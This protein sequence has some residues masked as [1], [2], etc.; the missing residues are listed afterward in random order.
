MQTLGTRA[1]E[2]EGPTH[3]AA[4]FLLGVNLRRERAA[5]EVG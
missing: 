3:L 1:M 2:T 5:R 4:T